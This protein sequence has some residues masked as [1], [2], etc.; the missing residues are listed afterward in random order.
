MKRKALSLMLVLLMVFSL[1]PASAFAANVVQSGSCEENL[2]WTLDDEGVLTITGTGEMSEIPE[3]ATVHWTLHKDSIRSVVIGS[4]VASIC[5]YAFSDCVNLTKVSIPNSVTK[6]GSSAFKGCT[7]LEEV[8][9]PGS[10]ATIKADAFSGCKGLKRIDLSNGIRVIESSAFRSCT[11]LT[12]V[13][14]PNG[15]EVLGGDAF[16]GCKGLKSVVIQNGVTR[17]NGW[18]FS[19]C[20]SLESVSI[21][22]SVKFIGCSAFVSCDALRDVYFGGTDMQWDSMEIEGD[23]EALD[24]ATIHFAQAYPFTDI[25]GSGYR[26]YILLGYMEGIINGYPDG[27][28]RPNNKVTRAQYITMLYN[29]CGKPRVYNSVISFVDAYEVS[30]PYKDAVKWGLDNGIINGYGDNT[31]RPNQEISRAQMAAFSYRLMK[32]VSGGEP[33]AELKADCGFKDSASI[34]KDYKEAVNV[35][36]N[37]GIITGF[38]TNNDGVGDTFRP[39]ATAN[40]GQ[41]ATIIVRL[42]TYLYSDE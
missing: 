33:D 37:L 15:I 3:D 1:L 7:S 16:N 21:P 19:G 28:F 18:T 38:D 11:G 23:N 8:V 25:A 2:T 6:I 10:V 20:S 31:F 13:E 9:V 24:S 42:D 17:I 32:L 12:S 36:A 29:M 30:G 22:S 4:G 39:N 5:D 41:A 26:N 40:R 14:L 35:M 34:A 27:T